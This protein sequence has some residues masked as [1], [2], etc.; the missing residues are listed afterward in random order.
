MYNGMKEER[1]Y[2]VRVFN[3]TGKL[4][5]VV[6]VDKLKNVHWEKFDEETPRERYANNFKMHTGQGNPYSVNYVPM[7]SDNSKTS[8]IQGEAV[9]LPKNLQGNPFPGTLEDFDEYF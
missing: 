5:K 1:L 3:K 2:P 6:Q 9:N 7:Y 4:M 8:G